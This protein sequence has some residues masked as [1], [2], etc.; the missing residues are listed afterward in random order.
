MKRIGLLC[1]GGDCAGLNAALRAVYARAHYGYGCTVVGIRNGTAG[2]MER[3]VQAEELGERAMS[4][5][6]LRLG[7]TILGTTNKGNPFK[8]PMEDGSFVD[9]SNEVIEAIAR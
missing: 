4:S 8:F 5:D 3:P 9:R 6:M 1:S 2:L 7:G